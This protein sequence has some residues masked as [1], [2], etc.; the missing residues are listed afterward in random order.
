MQFSYYHTQLCTERSGGYPLIQGP[1]IF[2]PKRDF[3][4]YATALNA[5][6]IAIAEINPDG[7]RLM[8]CTDREPGLQKGLVHA[9]GPTAIYFV[10]TLHLKQNVKD[11]LRSMGVDQKQY[12]KIVYRQLFDHD[13]SLAASKSKED[14]NIRMAEIDHHLFEEKYFEEYTKVIWENLVKPRIEFP[15]IS[16]TL[17]NNPA[18][19]QNHR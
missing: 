16:F 1:S 15:W 12:N 11:H 19:S 5:L 2:I 7:A 6:S 17:T 8:F 14:F 4:H 13:D 10:C 9:F 18:E 3:L